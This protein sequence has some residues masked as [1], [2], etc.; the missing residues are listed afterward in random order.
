M[1]V[2]HGSTVEVKNPDTNHS[3]RH[4][5][6]GTG[7]YVT[8]VSG[9][10]ERWA[11]RKS[12]LERKKS[13]IVNIYEL[14]NY[15]NMKV[16]DFDENLEEGLDF[17]CQCRDG[18]EEYKKYDIIIGKVADDKVFRVVDMYKR[19]IWDKER[20]LKEIRVYETYNQLAFIS[21]NAIDQ[22]LAFQGG[23]EV[24]CDG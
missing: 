24:K 9:Q 6:F 8:T 16:L 12:M 15:S 1:T 21:Q 2:Y 7:F 18:S 3:N 22:A 20:A 5:D 4:L 23:Y 14:K 10:A 13:G 19:G 17:V 11:K